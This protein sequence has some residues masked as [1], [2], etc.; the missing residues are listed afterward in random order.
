M[1]RNKVVTIDVFKFPNYRWQSK[2]GPEEEGEVEAGLA[3]K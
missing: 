1:T 3:W 2:C